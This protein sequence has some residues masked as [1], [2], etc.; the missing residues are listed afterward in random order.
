MSPAAPDT[1]W[2]RWASAADAAPPDD[3]HVVLP[4]L[5]TVLSGHAIRTPACE[6]TIR[7]GSEA[8]DT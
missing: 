5:D 3:S 2:R 7:D 6:K 4:S 8:W 1:L